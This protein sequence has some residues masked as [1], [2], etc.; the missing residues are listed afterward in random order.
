MERIYEGNC[1]EIFR[2]SPRIYFRK[3]NLAARRQCNSVYFVAENGVGVVDLPTM[4][5][6]EEMKAEVAQLFQKPLRYI[7]L[8]HAHPDHMDG[9]PAFENA[10]VTVFCSHRVLDEFIPRSG[11]SAVMV[12]VYGKTDFFVEGFKIELLNLEDTAHSPWDILV[13]FTE[14]DIMCT[15]DLIVEYSTLYFQSANPE[16]WIQNLREI[17]ARPGRF[18]L[19]GHGD[20]CPHSQAAAVADYIALLLRSAKKF[21]EPFKTA[22]IDP[23]ETP[24]IDKIVG[25]F[26]AGDSPDAMEIVEKAGMENGHRELRMMFRNI[27]NRRLR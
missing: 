5:A 8:T 12:G 11:G 23:I 14:E 17:A 13:R 1:V 27:L 21:L 2:V 4:E 7:F 18:I 24:E 15:G 16:R 3:G 6:S 22:F 25:D 26:L 20:M 19:P 10:P 9:L